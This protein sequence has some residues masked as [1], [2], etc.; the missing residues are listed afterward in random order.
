MTDFSW[1]PALLWGV[2]ILAGFWPGAEPPRVLDK[3]K[4]GYWTVSTVFWPLRKAY[5]D[6]WPC[7]AVLQNGLRDAWL[8]A[9][10]IAAIVTTVTDWF[11]LA[12]LV[13][14]GWLMAEIAAVA[15]LLGRA[16][17]FWSADRRIIKAQQ[18]DEAVEAQAE[19]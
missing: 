15:F 10:A 9:F 14:A 4:R 17:G 1:V 7:H 8:L 12:K 19:T 18:A 16:S 2:V 3:P 11:H 5:H 6:L 13:P